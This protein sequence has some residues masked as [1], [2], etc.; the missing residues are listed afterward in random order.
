MA[1]AEEALHAR[2]VALAEGGVHKGS[3]A[4][5]GR[6]L[7]RGEKEVRGRCEGGEKEAGGGGREASLEWGPLQGTGLYPKWNTKP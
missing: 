4:E 6:P 7:R 5:G 3:V 1:R 2:G